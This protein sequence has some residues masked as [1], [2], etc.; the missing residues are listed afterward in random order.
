METRGVPFFEAPSR[1]RYYLEAQFPRS[2]D[3][4]ALIAELHGSPSSHKG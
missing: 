4:D 1:G 2:V 3:D